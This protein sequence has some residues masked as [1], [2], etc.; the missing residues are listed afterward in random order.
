M[1]K[2]VSAG[3]MGPPMA[4]GSSRPPMAGGA[5][6]PPMAGGPGSFP[7]CGPPMA[8]GAGIGGMMR[9][10]MAGGMRSK[11]KIRFQKK[12]DSSDS[13]DEEEEL[14]SRSKY[15]NGPELDQLMS[16]SKMNGLWPA[17][18]YSFIS[19]LKLLLFKKEKPSSNA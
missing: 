14:R 10:P 2:G 6:L 11:M 16:L 13:S 4:G 7:M 12:A 17:K 5:S 8:G 18:G 3:G 1:F 19:P 9:P 15:H